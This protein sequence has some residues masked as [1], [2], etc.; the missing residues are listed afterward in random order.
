MVAIPI[1]VLSLAA[2]SV[3][4]AIRLA[5]DDAAKWHQDPLTVQTPNTPNWYRLTPA[6][7]GVQA[8]PKRDDDSPVFDVPVAE[9]ESAFDEV[10]TGDSRVSVL[11]GSAAEGFVTYLQRSALM[12]YPDYVSV[13]FI[14]VD[15]SRSTLAVFSRPRYGSG[16][17]DVNEKRVRRWIQGT[18]DLLN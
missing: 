3:S 11:D 7:A 16:D 5:S 1:A 2:V 6:D 8:D 14:E 10:A 15:E 18:H 17:L 12:G 9:L 13:R 4:V